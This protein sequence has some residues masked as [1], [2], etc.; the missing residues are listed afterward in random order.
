[1]STARMLTNGLIPAH[2]ECPYSSECTLRMD[3]ECGH[4]G[5]AH[6]V[7]YSC[8]LARLFDIDRRSVTEEQAK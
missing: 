1:M 5:T 7:A 3:D 2:T 4:G 8:G 6:K